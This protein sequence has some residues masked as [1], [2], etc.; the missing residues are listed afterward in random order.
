R[1]FPEPA[2]IEDTHATALALNDRL[3]LHLPEQF[4]DGLTG[5]RQHHAEALLRDPHAARRLGL[6]LTISL[7]QVDQTARESDPGRLQRQV[8]E[9]RERDP[10]LSHGPSSQ[11]LPHA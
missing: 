5:E 7:E 1:R 2:G 9:Q 6:S 10:K 8:L 3:L 11:M 4:V